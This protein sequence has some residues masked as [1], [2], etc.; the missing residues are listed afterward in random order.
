MADDGIARLAE[1]HA[2][3][4]AGGVERISQRD[5]LLSVAYRCPFWKCDEGIAHVT[6]QVEQHQEHHRVRS[7]RF[8]EWLLVEAGREFPMEVAGQERPGSFGKNAMED[9]LL[10]CEAMATASD[11]KMAAPLRVAQRDGYLYLDL[12]DA[13]WHAVEIGPDG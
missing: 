10:A 4:D 7:Q 6:I 1:L 3:K 9:A 5:K 8:R 13:E 2:R 12:G 11:V